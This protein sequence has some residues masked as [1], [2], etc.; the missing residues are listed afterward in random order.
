MSKKLAAQTIDATSPNLLTL[1]A[2]RSLNQF[3][4]RP[5]LQFF[6]PLDTFHNYRSLP[7]PFAVWFLLKDVTVNEKVFAK[8]Y[9][10]AFVF[11]F[12]WILNLCSY[13]DFCM[14]FNDLSTV[15]DII[16]KQIEF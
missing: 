15:S 1:K 4:K 2:V 9:K 13:P 10:D 12:N 14:T 6:P 5:H 11:Y 16:D 8:F 7:L 3:F